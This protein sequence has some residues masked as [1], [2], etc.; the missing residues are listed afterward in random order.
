[1][2]VSVL[3]TGAFG[4][5]GSAIVSVLQQQHPEWTLSVLDRQQPTDPHS[6]IRYWH[7]DITE[8][9]RLE[10]VISKIKPTVIIHAA[11]L[12]PAL[13]DRYGRK[14]RGKVFQVNVGG[15]RN[16]LAAA[17]NHGVEAFVWTGSCTAVTDDFSR[18]YPN[19]DE[20]WPT[21]GHSLIY[22]ES[23]TAAEALVLAASSSQMATCSLRPSVIF[24]P[25]D[26][27]TIP[28][29][30]ACVAK[31]ETPFIIGDGLNMWDIT[32]VSNVADAH[33]L[34]VEN[35]LSS[36]TAAGQ[37]IFISN[38]QPLPFRDFCLAVWREFG[39]APS[40]EV[41]IP[42]GLAA[43]A[44][45][46]AEWATWLTGSPS[47][48]SRGSVKDACQV[49]HVAESHLYHTIH[50]KLEPKRL[51]GFVV[52]G[53]LH[54]LERL[55]CNLRQPHRQRYVSNIRLEACPSAT[56][57]VIRRQNAL[58]QLLPRLASLKLQ[59]APSDLDFSK[60]AT[61]RRL[62][63]GFLRYTLEDTD[64]G[65]PEFVI[66][67]ELFSCSLDLPRLE[68]LS[69]SHLDG[70]YNHWSG[71]FPEKRIRTSYITTLRILKADHTYIP[72]LP[73]VLRSIVA[74]ERFTFQLL[75]LHGYNGFFPTGA[76]PHE[77][78]L[79]ISQQSGTLKEL[80]IPY[81]DAGSFV[82]ANLFGSL[83]G[84]PRLQRL[85]ISDNFL[86]PLEAS[87]WV[88]YHELL[89]ASLEELQLQC[90]FKLDRDF[91]GN[92]VS[93]CPKFVRERDARV[94]RLRQLARCRKERLPSLKSVTWWDQHVIT[95]MDPATRGC[96]PKIKNLRRY[97]GQ[98]GISFECIEELV[99][100]KT[101]FGKGEAQE[102]C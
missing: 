100:D 102:F 6:K 29:L 73:L 80:S 53:N 76:S 20:S 61:L 88:S 72:V 22:G 7:C 60:L 41:T 70:L 5:V 9:T 77:L 46:V 47:T 89:P 21:S 69:V 81:A 19:I 30:H 18:Q 12:V 99:W 59:P 52:S 40:F 90:P 38:E 98:H 64:I 50:L 55:T 2:V 79:A 17:K 24:G 44:G 57:V 96:E 91:I 42:V 95:R 85:A 26:P 78:A 84:Y 67:P 31:H 63:L 92:R 3:V 4:F 62:H 49:R 35:L 23:K 15:T 71:Y 14:A 36:K 25:G 94:K 74:L 83:A 8:N 51:D 48:L 45:Y 27:Q 34:A 56:D 54:Q 43:F 97:L 86:C 58:I 65:D 16:L 33:V 82:P 93:A 37:T 11:G 68:T 87:G 75:Q 39:H 13:I 101:P 10:G 66:S 32:Y 28:S 1:M